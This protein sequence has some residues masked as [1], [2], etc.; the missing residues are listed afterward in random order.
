MEVRIYLENYQIDTDENSIIAMTMC[1]SYLEDP[2][3]VAGDYSKTIKI[4]GTVNNNKIFGQIWNLDRTVLYGDSNTSVYFN[5]SKKTEAKI[6]IGPELFKTGYVQLNN[7]IKDKNVITYE[8]TFY[9]ELCNVLHNLLDSSL[10]NLNLPSNGL[11]HVINAYNIDSINNSDNNSL[12]NYMKYGLTIDGVYDGFRADYWLTKDSSGN[13]AVGQID[14]NGTKYDTAM[15]LQAYSPKVRPMI[16]VSTLL[17]QIRDDYNK[18][19][20]TKLIYDDDYFFNGA[21]PYCVNSVMTCKTYD[22]DNASTVQVSLNAENFTASFGADGGRVRLELIPGTSSYVDENGYL[23]LSSL[24]T[25]TDLRFEC[26]LRIAGTLNQSQWQ[27]ATSSY[28]NNY[29]GRRFTSDFGYIQPRIVLVNAETGADVSY[30][31]STN[32]PW[33]SSEIPLYEQ[34]STHYYPYVTSPIIYEQDYNTPTFELAFQNSFI[35]EIT[36][37]DIPNSNGNVVEVPQYSKMYNNLDTKGYLDLDDEDGLMHDYIGVTDFFPFTFST[38]DT[39]SLTGKYKV[40][41]EFITYSNKLKCVNKG[42]TSTEIDITGWTIYG[43]CGVAENYKNNNYEYI[44]RNTQNFQA[45]NASL[46]PN[47]PVVSTSGKNCSLSG[48]TGITSGSYVSFKDMVDSDITQGDF[49]IN[50]SKLFGLVYDSD[51]IALDNTIR[52]KTRNSYHKDYKILDWTDK[53]DYSKSFKQTPL[54]FKTKYLSLAYNPMDSY[55]EKKYLKTYDDAYG[56]QKI[57]TGFDFNDNTT[58]LLNNQLFKQTVMVKGEA[59]LNGGPV[60]AYFDKANNERS[61]IDAQY[62]LL[63][64]NQDSSLNNYTPFIQIIDDIN[65]MH[66]ASIGGDEEPCWV[67]TSRVSNYKNV[68]LHAPSTLRSHEVQQADDKKIT[69]VFSWDLGYPQSNYAKWSTSTYPSSATIYSNYWKSYIADLYDVNT[70]ILRC[71]VYLSPIE[72]TKFSFKDFVKIGDTLWH[73]NQIIDYNPLSNNPVQVEL[74]KVNDISAYTNSQTK[75]YDYI[76]ATFTV[77]SSDVPSTFRIRNASAA[78]TDILTPVSGSVITTLSG[79]NNYISKF[80]RGTGFTQSFC[81]VGNYNDIYTVTA[82]YFDSTTGQNIDCS[83]WFNKD[84]LTFTVPD[85]TVNGPITVNI[86]VKSG[87]AFYNIICE[88]NDENNVKYTPVIPSETIPS[89]LPEGSELKIL[90]SNNSTSDKLVLASKSVTMG[91]N[92]I[93]SSAFDESTGYVHIQTVTGDVILNFAYIDTADV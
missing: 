1:Y 44:Y 74:I 89:R 23:D 55:Y 51:S 7:I 37:Q 13:L 22:T 85:K 63:F 59:L 91:G 62:S 9:S 26:M 43:R 84:T 58:Q 88:D 17:N 69:H 11:R 24:T 33:N 3:T 30:I 80:L 10:C 81:Y 38:Y 36:T 6:Y 78:Q 77:T 52:L 25:T 32:T 49:L 16:Y 86:D 93:T 56:I 64:W 35:S 42:D 46:H 15:L 14:N 67:D 48:S 53:I 50:F 29:Y 57:D 76:D 54:T 47:C 87:I 40:Y 20:S 27:S 21:N 4:P 75:W 71:Y 45:F 83:S 73:P 2:T 79:N 5:P 72:M 31:Y 82:K 41:V 28:S 60:P 61:P 39:S 8:I 65:E 70:R 19:S 12:G 92:N 18:D 68:R 66:D 34:Y 90:V